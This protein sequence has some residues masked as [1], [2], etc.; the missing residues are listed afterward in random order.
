MNGNVISGVKTVE[1]NNN[2]GQTEEQKNQQQEKTWGDLK[3]DSRASLDWEVMPVESIGH[4]IIINSA[5]LMMTIRERMQK[6]FHDFAGVDIFVPKPGRQ[7]FECRFAFWYNPAPVPEGKIKSLVDVT[8]VKPNENSFYNMKQASN[9]IINGVKYELNDETKLL[10]SDMLYGGRKANMPNSKNWNNRDNVEQSVIQIRNDF[11]G[12][13]QRSSTN[14]QI[15][16]D[17]KNVDL[18][19]VLK[20]L[21]GKSMII[22]TTKD[23]AGKTVN[24]SVDCLYNPISYTG[25]PDNTFDITISQFDPNAVRKLFAQQHPMQFCSINGGRTFY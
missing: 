23:S 25:R 19:L 15:Y 4:S 20:K 16:V 8:K 14:V 1:L 7:V 5:V 22:S 18:R 3:L 17:V 10:I 24:Y 13:Y 6:T 21:F 12:Y 9:H 11:S 2:N